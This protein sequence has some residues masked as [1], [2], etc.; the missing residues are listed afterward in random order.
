MC[1][2]FIGTGEFPAQMASN[3]ENVSI[4]WRHHNINC[5]L[6]PLSCKNKAVVIVE[7]YNT[8]LQQI[9]NS[10]FHDQNPPQF[11]VGITRIYFGF[12]RKIFIKIL[13]TREI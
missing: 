2:E 11:T 1:G 6:D 13:T 9:Q 12:E 3:V 7:K 10:S 8:S 5:Q 4:W